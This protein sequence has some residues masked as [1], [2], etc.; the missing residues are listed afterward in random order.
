MS[1]S[2]PNTWRPKANETRVGSPALMPP[3]RYW[4]LLAERQSNGHIARLRAGF[5]ARQNEFLPSSL[6]PP[7]PDALQLLEQVA[8]DGWLR[9]EKRIRC[10]HC[11]QALSGE[12]AAEA[13]CPHCQESLGAG[14]DV[15]SETV[16]VRDLL[17]SRDVDWVIAIHGM[18]TSGAWQEAFS[19]RLATT[20]GRSVPVAVY[21]YGIIIAGVILAWRRRKL[22]NDLRLKLATLRDE[23]RAQGFQ[24]NPDVIA[25]SFGTW[26]FGHLLEEELTRGAADPLRFGRLILTGCVLRPDFDWGKIKE[27]GLVTHILNHYGTNDRVVPFAHA[28]IFDSGPSGRRGFDG[29]EVINVRAEGFGHSDLFSIDRFVSNGETFQKRSGNPGA[30]SHLDYAYGRYWKPFLTLPAAEFDLLRDRSDPPNRWRQMPW[31]FR[32]TI[33]PFLA[34]P[35]ILS[36]AAFALSLLGAQAEKALWVFRPILIVTGAGLA[37]ILLCTALIILCRRGRS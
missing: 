6:G 32:G 33:F 37:S 19:W 21:K 23:A 10:A 2:A 20:W 34:L 16:Y 30:V 28:T 8:K 26:L 4:A 36:L 12:E 31:L 25:H 3:D 17:P 18:N 15:V 35:L 27:A 1:P 29:R 9:I 14:Q 13:S 11:E 22:Q 24:G 7:E 5:E